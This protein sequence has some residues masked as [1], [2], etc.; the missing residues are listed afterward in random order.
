[1]PPREPRQSAHQ[2]GYTAR[3]AKASKAFRIRYPLCGM[4]PFGVVPFMSQCWDEGR[5]TAAT[6][7]DHVRPHRGDRRLFWDEA[8]WQALCRACGARKSQAGW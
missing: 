4:R 8:N 2:R 3:W 7:T 6:Q 1:M 5:T